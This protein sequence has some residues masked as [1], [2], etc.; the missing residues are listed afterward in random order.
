[1]VVGFR[2]A[3]RWTR[4]TLA[5]P[6]AMVCVPLLALSGC[7]PDRAEPPQRVIWIAVDSLRAD[8]LGAY[9]YPLGTSPWIDQFARDSV[10]FEWAISPSNHTIRSVAGYF[11]G[12]P[13][14]AIHANATAIGI[15]DRETTLAE[16]LQA[17][18]VRTH[19]WTANLNVIERWG[20]HQGFDTFHV[21]APPGRGTAYIDEVISD[22]RAEYRR[23][24]DREF[25][26]IHTMDVHLPYRPAHPFGARFAQPYAGSRVRE[27]AMTQEDG[28]T[29]LFS[30]H[31]YWSGNVDVAPEDVAYLRR[32]YDACIA[33]TDSKLPDLLAAL[34]WDPKRDVVILTSDHGEHL[35]EEGW[36]SHFA[37]LTP[38]EVRVPLIVNH[39][40]LKARTVSTQVGLTDLY[41]TVLDLF[42]IAGEHQPFASSLVPVLKGESLAEHL[43]YTESSPKNGLS[44]ALISDTSWYWV[45]MNRSQIEPW[46][47]WPYEEHLY[48]YRADADAAEDLIASGESA[49]NDM[50][51]R[52]RA[53]NPRWTEFS[54][55]RIGGDDDSV[56]FGE[57]LLTSV[58][59]DGTSS[60]LEMDPDGG[61]W[62]VR[63]D[64]VE[65]KFEAS[66]LVPYEPVFLELEYEMH[67][68]RIVLDAPHVEYLLP[69]RGLPAE[70]WSHVLSRPTVGECF[71]SVLV[72]L[73]DRL[74]LSVRFEPGTNAAIRPP[75]LRRMLFERVEPWPQLP[76]SRDPNFG[77]EPE[78][79]E[80]LRTLGYV[81]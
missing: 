32:L 11:T 59:T 75:T 23:S 19:A 35:F 46:H 76:E 63:S 26:Y 29:Q 73:G 48:R 80:Q 34:D 55:D 21:L 15:P 42:G 66:G 43:V 67:A 74:Q 49:A 53:Y 41:P 20:Y 33:Y 7:R 3:G 81:H 8:H 78:Y 79:M 5:A 13:Y 16:A 10:R 12:K 64:P 71:A 9:G 44:A 51:E 18:G 72:P 61:G 37:T 45:V 24:D 31:P 77:V 17:A 30:S 38:R 52:L 40:G 47:P 14:T 36:W 57:N 56:K 27:G 6:A 62:I 2:R 28:V 1:M 54:R 58:G 22:V 25:I 68:G 70:D 69:A 39:A 50:N 60:T 65:L 4:R